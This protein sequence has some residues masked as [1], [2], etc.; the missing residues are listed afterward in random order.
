MAGEGATHYF[1]VPE[2]RAVV[3]ELYRRFLCSVNTYDDHPTGYGLDEY[4]LDIWG[5][6]GR[7]DPLPEER[8][9]DIIAFLFSDDHPLT[10]QWLISGGMIWQPSTGWVEYWDPTDMH[11]DHIHCTLW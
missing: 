3:A 1:W 7:G 4:S 9:P 6:Y 11:Y 5:R 8:W 2:V 10:V